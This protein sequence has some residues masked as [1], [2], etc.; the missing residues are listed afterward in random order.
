MWYGVSTIAA[1]M[2]T[3]LLTP[4]LAYTLT[5]EDGRFVIGQYGYLY[6]LFPIMNVLYTYGMETSFFRFS[7]TE[8]DKRLYNTQTSAMLFTT[9]LFSLCLFLFKEQVADFAKLGTHIEYV[10]WCAAIIGLDALSALPFAK[11][12]NENRPRVYA[13]TKVAGIVV[14]VATIV[15]LFS[16]GKTVADSNPQG[17]FSSWYHEHY[18]IGFILY[19]NL[20]QAAITLLLLYKG[21][22]SYKPR[23]DKALLQKVM[24]YGFPILIT[25]FAGQINDTINRTMFIELH[26]GSEIENV[27]AIGS[28]TMAVRLATLI[29][30]MIQA[31]KMAAEPFFFSISQDKDARP[32]YAR[33]M[34]WFVIL[35]AIMFLNVMLYLDVWKLFIGEH[36]QA[37]HLVPVMLMYYI[38]LGVYYNLT[39]WYKLTDKTYFGTYIMLIG[40]AVTIIFN[41][42]LIP[43]W[44][45][46]ACAWGTLVCYGVMMYLSF[47]WGQKYYPIPYDVKGMAK[48][49]GVMLLLYALQAILSRY[50]NIPILRIGTGTV[51]FASY[52]FYIF[53][54]EKNELKGFPV[55]GKYIR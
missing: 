1:R 38:F 11:L 22:S 36:I 19:A 42:M 54:Q 32:T 8:D 30:L 39:I 34:K 17:W 5:G 55:I 43:V 7:K 28:F 4:Y 2:L 15:F 9:L 16:F 27:K 6:S 20:L 47:I 52:F 33:V 14:F 13:F 18:G 44:G 12:R 51:L 10:G 26:P 49:L 53:K 21:W 45:Y 40:A 23:I 35:M 29:N 46:D 3:F 50:I 24:V 31:F 41:W 25:G 48:H 37:I